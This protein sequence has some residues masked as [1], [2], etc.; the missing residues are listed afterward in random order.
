[1]HPAPTGLPAGVPQLGSSG[2]PGTDSAWISAGSNQASTIGRLSVPQT[3]TMAAQVENHAGAALPGGGWSSTPAPATPTAAGAP[4]MP[5]IPVGNSGGR[6]FGNGP[7][8]GFQVT[9]MP[10][11][12]AAG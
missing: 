9:V 12:P 2:I 8:Y 4:G 3:W 7:R 10:R 11:P 6:N 1:M 5:G